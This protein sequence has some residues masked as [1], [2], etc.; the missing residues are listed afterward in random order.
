[1]EVAEL[2]PSSRNP[3]PLQN[4]LL[5]NLSADKEK[6]SSVA[7]IKVVVCSCHVD[8]TEYL[9]K[10]GFVFDA[11]LDED[12]SNDEV[13]MLQVPKSA[14]TINQLHLVVLNS[15][16]IV[17]GSGKTY[18]MQPLPL[19][20]S[21]DILRLMHHTYRYQGFQL[22]VSFF[23]IYGGKLFDLLNDRRFANVF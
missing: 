1:M 20:A 11:V 12:V 7:K 9:E 23:E 16:L 21:H 6:T 22:Y 17:S 5:K 19:K 3:V 13:T 8:L 18:T 14:F 2:L 10:H 4:N 15:F